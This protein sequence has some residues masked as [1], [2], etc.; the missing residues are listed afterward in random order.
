MGSRIRREDEEIVHV[1]NKPSFSDHVSEGIIHES[2]KGGGGV[3]ESKEH[4]C[5]FKEAFVG[6]EHCFP[7]VAVLDP[8]I[9][10]SPTNIEF[11]EDLSIF[12]FINEVR[13]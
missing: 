13:D 3:G 12:E 8:N 10:V 6:D 9:V 7:L 11:G 2:L 5:R 1:D 4:D